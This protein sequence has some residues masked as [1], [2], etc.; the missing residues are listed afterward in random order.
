M[1]TFLVIGLG[2]F[3]TNLALRLMELGNEVMAVDQDEEAVNR[4]AP[5][6]TQAKIADCMDEAALRALGVDHFDFCFVCI[7]QQFQSSLEITSLLKELGA[8]MVVAKANRDLHARLLKKIGADE[9]V[10]PERDM[11]RRTAVRYSVNG[12]LEYIELSP[13]YAIFE[14]DVPAWW[15]GR[16]LVELNIRSK[17]N[18]NLIGI[19]ENGIV[20]PITSPQYV[21]RACDHVLAAGESG[22]V[23]HMMQDKG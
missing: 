5:H 15:E 22:A 2:R 20:R 9:V 12:A 13:D 18:V 10:F 11:A 8:P 17:Y 19:K 6:V 16:S 14:L 21:F 1:A 4:M 7:S 3:G 23:A